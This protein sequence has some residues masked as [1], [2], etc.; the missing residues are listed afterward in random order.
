MI[1]TLGLGMTWKKALIVALVIV[2]VVIGVPIMVHGMD[3]ASCAECGPAVMA[4]PCIPL[5]LGTFALMV[6]LAS[7]LVRRRRTEPFEL[8]RAC[9]L[10]RPPQLA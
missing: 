10:D 6:A 3:M 2:L 4:G 5:F 8:L 1:G 9:L 7:F